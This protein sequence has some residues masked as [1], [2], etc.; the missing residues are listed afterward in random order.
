VAAL[1]GGG[2]L[3][4]RWGR[5]ASSPLNPA[6]I[7]SNERGKLIQRQRQP[8]RG[9]GLSGGFFSGAGLIEGEE[10][11]EDVGVGGHGVG[12]ADGGIEPGLGLGLGVAQGV[13]ISCVYSRHC[14]Q[15]PN[16]RH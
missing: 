15:R 2:F 6:A 14:G 16:R 9:D 7:P 11:G 3:I 5:V 8:R 1:S 10:E 13:T 12:G 4:L